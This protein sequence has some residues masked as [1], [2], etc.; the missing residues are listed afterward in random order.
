MLERVPL[1]PLEGVRGHAIKVA[2]KFN[3][4]VFNLKNA[5]V[6]E[7]LMSYLNVQNDVIRPILSDDLPD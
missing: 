2:D 4:P 6:E 7:Q 5:N 3:I 1:E